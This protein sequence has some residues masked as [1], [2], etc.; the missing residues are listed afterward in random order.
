M[1]LQVIG[2]GFGRT[3]TKSLKQALEMIGFG[4][5]HHMMEV[6]VTPGQLDFWCD[7][8]ERKP[9][10]WH[11]VFKGFRAAVDWPSCNYWREMA[12]AFPEAKI[13]HS[14]RP[15]E[16]WWASFS[17][18]IAD[19]LSTPPATDDPDRLRHRRMTEVIINQ[20]VFGGRM[21]DKAVALE[22]FRRREAEVRAAV[23]PEKLLVM[24]PED[25]WAEL[26]P[27]LG[28]PVPAEPYPF[29]N[30]TAEFR[31]R[32]GQPPLAAG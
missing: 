9:V 32:A 30:T 3:G 24:R 14:T 29:T 23:P 20:D 21:T 26:C 13:I 10:D 18:T 25:G 22:A 8:A 7:I 4:P 15:P 19:S 17:K 2:S 27:F 12:A 1:S 6:R 16:Q 5:C 31:E 11:K 28:V